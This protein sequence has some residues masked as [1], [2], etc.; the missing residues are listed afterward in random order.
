MKIFII[1]MDDPIITNMFMKKIIRNRHK[2]VI[3]ISQP[4]GDRTTT[5][6]KSKYE[7]L[8]CLFWI[9]GPLIF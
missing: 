2:D 4:I 3:G 5:F 8:F 9:L 7:Y 6:N 1:T